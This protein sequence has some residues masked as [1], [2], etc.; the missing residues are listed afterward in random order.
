M[1]A[2]DDDDDD[3]DDDEVRSRGVDVPVEGDVCGGRRY[4]RK[5]KSFARKMSVRRM[6]A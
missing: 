6:S 3:D 4:G 1:P 2:V 5:E